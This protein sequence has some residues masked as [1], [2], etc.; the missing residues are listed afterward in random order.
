MQKKITMQASHFRQR[1]NSLIFG[2]EHWIKIVSE[3]FLVVQNY[4]FRSNFTMQEALSVAKF[5][6]FSEVLEIYYKLFKIDL[7]TIYFAV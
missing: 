5:A 3:S 7:L 6:T 2:K 4:G 1:N